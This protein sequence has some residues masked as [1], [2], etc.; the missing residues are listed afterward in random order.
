MH[1]SMGTGEHR[2]LYLPQA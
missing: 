1:I 2:Y